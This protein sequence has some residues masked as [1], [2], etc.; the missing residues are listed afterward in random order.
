LGQRGAGAQ[1]HGQVRL[2]AVLMDNLRPPHEAELEAHDEPPLYLKRLAAGAVPGGSFVLQA[3]EE[4]T[5]M[6]QVEVL[7]IVV[8][9]ATG[10]VVSLLRLAGAVPGG[11]FVVR[12]V[13]RLGFLWEWLPIGVSPQGQH[14]HRESVLLLEHGCD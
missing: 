10:A 7:S 3:E 12:A 13:P 8:V 11:I 2:G 6:A 5:S 14:L 9:T 1:F 4:V